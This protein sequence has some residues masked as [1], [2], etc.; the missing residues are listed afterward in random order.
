[1]FQ[2]ERNQSISVIVTAHVE[3]S[4]LEETLISIMSN[5]DLLIT[6]NMFN[7]SYE[8]IIALDDP[9]TNTVEIADRFNCKHKNILINKFTDLGKNRNNAIKNSK[10][11]YISLVDGDDIWGSTWLFKCFQKINSKNHEIFRPENIVYFGEDLELG[12]QENL[13]IKG[14]KSISKENVWISSVFTHKDV[15]EQIPFAEL[16]EIKPGDFEDWKWNRDTIKANY[17]HRII[18]G[19]THFVRKK[20]ESY[21]QRLIKNWNENGS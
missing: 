9:D 5:I 21:S 20:S 6:L 18:K 14:A 17:S 2:S 16:Y 19:T 3:G 11:Q 13:K 4:I 7:W 12:F 1:M 10:Y 8:I 15:F